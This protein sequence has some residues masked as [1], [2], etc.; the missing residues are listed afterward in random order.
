MKTCKYSV[1]FTLAV[2]GVLIALTVSATAA[3]PVYIFGCHDAS[4]YPRIEAAEKTGWLTITKAIGHDP[5]DHSGDDFSLYSNRGHGVIVRLN[6]GYESDGTLPNSAY[7]S[8][9]ATRCANYVAA[10]TG[11]DIFIIGNEPNLPREWP[12]NVNGDPATGQPIT[13]ARYQT[14]YIQ[15]YNAIKAVRSSAVVCPAPAGTWAPPYSGQGI[16]GFLDYWVNVLNGV[17]ASKVDALIIHAYTHGCAPALVTD[18][19]LMQPP[20]SSIYYNFQVYK[21]YMNAI[22]T[23]MRSLPVYITECDENVECADTGGGA[24]YHTWY[25][26]N[27]GWVKAIYSEINTWNNTGG[28]QKIRCV[29]LYRY[30]D[31]GEGNWAFGFSGRSGVLADWAE[32]MANNYR[33]D[34]NPTT[35]TLSGNVKDG[36]G[37]NVSGATVSTNTGGYTTTTDGSGNYTI[38]NVTP[39]TYN[40]TASKT[41]YNSQTQNNKTVTAGQTTTVNFTITRQTGTISGTVKDT[42]NVAINGATV[43]T[44]TGGYATTTNSS[45]AYTLS[46]V[47]TGTYSV[48]ASKSGYLTQTNSN[49]T[50]TYNNTTTS[51]F[52]LPANTNPASLSNGSFEGGFTNGVANSWTQWITSGSPGFHDETGHIHGGSHA[53]NWISNSATHDA[54]IYQR[55]ASGAGYTYTFSAWTWRLGTSSEYTYVGIDPTGGT[56]PTSG[57]I[58]WSGSQNS[59]NTW[60]QQ[61]CSATSGSNGY[62][63]VF[64]RGY[65]QYPYSTMM[66][67]VDDAAL[68]YTGGSTGTISGDV[69]DSSN[70]PISGA[71][72]STNTGGY[73][74]TTAANGTYTLSNVAVGTYNVTASKSG[75]TPQTQNNVV[76]TQ[77]NVT[78]CNF[79]LA[80]G[81]LASQDFEAMPTWSSS[82]DAGWGGAA[83]WSIVSG[84]QSGNFLQASRTSQGS[85]SKVLVY[86]VP[87]NTNIT[88]SVY[89]KCPSYSNSYW[90]E[91]A[92]KLGSQTASDFDGN[93]ATWTYIKKFANDG[94]NGNGN[95]WT[96]YSVSL[97]TGSNTQISV[98]F[99]HGASGNNG[100]TVGWDTFRIN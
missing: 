59:N 8:N 46:G 63:T 30:D 38:N 83:T 28:N 55:M 7:Y 20:Y 34:T 94:T 61:S 84:G 100:P 50:V 43:S 93:A 57:N 78:N 1:R 56:N 44:D 64:V 42:N 73:T 16:E 51:N 76:V 3:T 9:F 95:T 32:A 96:Q 87:S 18:Q 6:N 92:C 75:Y 27:N 65:A 79:T 36:G 68:S 17:G 35:G 80:A 29:C 58:V 99:K 33:W 10:T 22:P 90:M 5:N 97:N 41:G 66:S 37:A 77:G 23:A 4:G 71:T 54:G 98:G 67:V 86:T 91:C 60:T 85:S 45:G 82:F 70:N 62:I 12:G 74:T 47:A 21:N 49:V 52:S 53:Q 69:K 40:V 25:N 89:M 26:S 39:G 13:S 48:S 81:N 15:C 31:V 24:P 88:L 19:T 2:L 72:V 11:A 14:C